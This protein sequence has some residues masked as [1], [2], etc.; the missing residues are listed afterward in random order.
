MYHEAQI[1][2]SKQRNVLM[3]GLM[4]PHLSHPEFHLLEN[5]MVIILMSVSGILSYALVLGY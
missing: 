3:N 1:T 4:N 5:I 2:D